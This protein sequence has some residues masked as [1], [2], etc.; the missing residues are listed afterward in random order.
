MNA[1]VGIY[2][3]WD[4]GAYGSRGRQNIFEKNFLSCACHRF[5]RKPLIRLAGG[6]GAVEF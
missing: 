5:S 4:G 3:K 1:P 6:F 2:V